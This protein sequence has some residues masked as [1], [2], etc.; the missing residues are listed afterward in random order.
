MYIVMYTSEIDGNWKVYSSFAS[1]QSAESCV[2]TLQEQEDTKDDP[3]VTISIAKVRKTYNHS[4]VM[5]D[6]ED[7]E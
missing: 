1:L 6:Y 2:Q 5:T 3:L 4:W 7:F